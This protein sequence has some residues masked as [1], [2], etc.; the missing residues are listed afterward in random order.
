M[1]AE[2]CSHVSQMP[3]LVSTL[4][5]ISSHPRQKFIILL[6]HVRVRK[7]SWRQI[8]PLGD[9]HHRP[10]SDHVLDKYTA[11][12]MG[13]SELLGS[14]SLV[15]LHD[16]CRSLGGSAECRVH[17]FCCTYSKRASSELWPTG[18]LQDRMHLPHNWPPSSPF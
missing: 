18:S 12:L 16:S 5:L 15:V 2:L 8:S 3:E 17:L 11:R 10:A 1:T 7:Q 13:C 6:S 14:R 4:I 9:G